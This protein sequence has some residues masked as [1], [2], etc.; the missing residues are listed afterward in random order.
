MAKAE[1]TNIIDEIKV[2]EIDERNISV[3]SEIDVSDTQNETYA[4]NIR[5]ELLYLINHTL[6]H[7]AYIK[8]LAQQSGITLSSHIGVAPSTASHLRKLGTH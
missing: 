4:S 8:L 2:L 6:H 1:L 7:A 3:I 5:R